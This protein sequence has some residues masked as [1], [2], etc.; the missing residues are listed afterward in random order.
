MSENEKID[1]AKMIFAKTLIAFKLM[2]INSRFDIDR[3]KV[4]RENTHIM[5]INENLIRVNA[6]L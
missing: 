6:I 3:A 5:E 4:I 2:R 1:H